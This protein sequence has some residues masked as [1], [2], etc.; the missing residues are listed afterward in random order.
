MIWNNTYIDYGKGGERPGFNALECKFNPDS[1]GIRD[2]EN[3]DFSL[4]SSSLAIDKGQKSVWFQGFETLSAGSQRGRSQAFPDSI[5]IADYAGN[6]P[7]LGAYEYGTDPWKPGHDWGEP[8]WVYPYNP[9]ELYTARQTPSWKFMQPQL[10]HKPGSLLISGSHWELNVYDAKG[11]LIF[12]RSWEQ[13]KSN[14][15]LVPLKTIACGIYY[16]ALKSQTGT[17]WIPVLVK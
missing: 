14:K 17:Q 6:A 15:C 16:A 1:C 8:D 11:A 13:A 3:F 12:H 5:R 10:A 4:L 9:S 2:A 7:D